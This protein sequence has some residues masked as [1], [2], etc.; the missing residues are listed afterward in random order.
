MGLG[1]D[2]L[3]YNL[4]I[5][6]ISLV[7]FLCRGQR[8]GGQ[9]ST[10]GRTP[11]GS[12]TPMVGSMTPS[13]SSMTP[14]HGGGGG[15]RTPMYGSQ[16]PLHGDGE[17]QNVITLTKITTMVA[18]YPGSTVTHVACYPW[19]NLVPMLPVTPLL[20]VQP[21]THVASYPGCMLPVASYPCCLFL[22]P[23][24]KPCGCK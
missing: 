9:T 17:W 10:W 5:Q 15:G 2:D 23:L 4:P 1:S 3:L 18:C 12:Q 6:Y 19:L 20:L 24:V 8:S 14:L 11:F 13:Y 22:L 21:C 16:T 7:L